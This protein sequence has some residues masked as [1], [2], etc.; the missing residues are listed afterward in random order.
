MTWHNIKFRCRRNRR[1]QRTIGAGTSRNRLESDEARALFDRND[2][3]PE[4]A[5]RR[6]Y[7]RVQK[8]GEITEVEEMP[9]P[10]PS[11]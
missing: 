4:D 10:D 1:V 3:F 9:R 8:T 11:H 5:W 6:Q 2:L 7:D